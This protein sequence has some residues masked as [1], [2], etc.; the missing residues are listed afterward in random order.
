MPQER[1][2][3][4]SVPAVIQEPP[5]LGWFTAG[6]YWFRRR[7]LE[8]QILE[9]ANN[10]AAH[11]SNGRKHGHARYKTLAE[12][13]RRNINAFLNHNPGQTSDL[14]LRAEIPVLDKIFQAELLDDP[15]SAT[16][17]WLKPA[18]MI[19]VGSYAAFFCLNYI[20]SGFGHVIYQY[21]ILLAPHGA[22]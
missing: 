13:T 3:Q 1:A 17:T 7:K 8:K 10:V 22:K 9:A 20:G 21:I 6:R 19:A 2:V 14:Q 16:P 15:T 4:A 11:E 12:Q 18:F 5:K